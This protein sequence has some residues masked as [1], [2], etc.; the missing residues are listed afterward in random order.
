[1]PFE[2]RPEPHEMLRPEGEYLRRAW[3]QSVYPLAERLG[4]PIRLPPVSPQPHTHLAWEGFQYA[5]ERGKGTE[6]NHRVLEGF[7]VHGLDIG[8][9]GV[10]TRLAGGVGLDEGE[11][12]AALRDR[13]YR[14]AHQQ[15]LWHAYEEAGVTGVPLFVIGRR[16]LTGVQDRETLAAVIAAEQAARGSG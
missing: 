10:L 15:A 1:M 6:Y 2:L 8:D 3:D 9:T 16:R 4:V 13:R 11:F 14:E 12:G 5:R 7:F